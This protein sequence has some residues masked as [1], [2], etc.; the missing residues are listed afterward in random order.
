MEVAVDGR[1]TYKRMVHH[2]STEV[3]AIKTLTKRS[4]IVVSLYLTVVMIYM[5]SLTGFLVRAK[6][7][8]SIGDWLI[9]YQGGFVRRGLLGEF[10]LRLSLQMHVSPIAVIVALQLTFYLLLLLAV[11]LLVRESGWALWVKAFLVSPATLAFPLLDLRGAFRKDVIYLAGLAVLLL[12]LRATPRSTLLITLY[13]A[14]LT[15]LLALSHEALLLFMPYCGAAVAICMRNLKQFLL[16]TMPA[17]AVALLCGIAVLTHH[18]STHEAKRVCASLGQERTNLCSGA[19]A[20]LAQD[21]SEARRQVLEMMKSVHPVA[22]YV[23]L[24]LLGVVPCAF[25]LASFWCEDNRR[26]EVGTLAAASL[27]AIGC[28]AVLF[29]YALDWG[30]WIHLHLFSLF[31]LCLFCDGLIM[32]SSPKPAGKTSWMGYILL[33]LYATAWDLP[34]MNRSRPPSGYVG[35]LHVLARQL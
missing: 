1:L 26:W 6:D 24:A 14:G 20:S 31:L 29:A 10:A 4:R 11:W 12:L 34:A 28:T 27:V 7:P 16:A 18:G 5:V 30:R 8:W 13:L 2:Y 22:M 32:K 25:A 23:V 21:T 17:F 3:A 19:I 9:N 15:A 33:M 35:I